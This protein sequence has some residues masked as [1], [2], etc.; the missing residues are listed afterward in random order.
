MTSHRLEQLLDYARALE[1]C[2]LHGR[3]NIADTRDLVKA[4]QELEAY[5]QMWP[6]MRR[7]RD[8]ESKA[9]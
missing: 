8:V 3:G 1:Q 6:S 9:A 4:L 5:R 7:V 2:A